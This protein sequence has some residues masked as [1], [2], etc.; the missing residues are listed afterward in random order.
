MRL[1]TLNIKIFGKQLSVEKSL[2]VTD[3]FVGPLFAL[4]WKI[5]KFSLP[6]IGTFG[7]KYLQWPNKQQKIFAKHLNFILVSN[8]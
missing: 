8:P 6:A 4:A 2:K 7:H 5:P 3:I 1:D